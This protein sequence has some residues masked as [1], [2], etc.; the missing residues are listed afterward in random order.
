MKLILKLFFCPPQSANSQPA[1]PASRCT[2]Q[3]CSRN[4]QAIKVARTFRL[5]CGQVACKVAPEPPIH[6]GF[7]AQELRTYC[8]IGCAD[9]SESCAVA[10]TRDRNHATKPQEHY[11]LQ[12]SDSPL[13]SGALKHSRNIALIPAYFLSDFIAIQSIGVELNNA[14]ED[15]IFNWGCDPRI[16]P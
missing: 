11:F 5:S 16:S 12:L 13:L 2:H 7:E 14:L 10:P 9:P 1:M 15:G 4:S 8:A 6:A 3:K